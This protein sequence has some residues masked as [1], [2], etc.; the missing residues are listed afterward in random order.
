MLSLMEKV[1]IYVVLLAMD[2]LFVFFF[3]AV[4]V[5]PIIFSMG[6]VIQLRGL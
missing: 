1:I 6:M 2:I 5:I 3:G 4:A